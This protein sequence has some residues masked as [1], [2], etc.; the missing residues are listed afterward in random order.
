MQGSQEL[1]HYKIMTARF[2]QLGPEWDTERFHPED[3]LIP[4]CRLYFPIAGEGRVTYLGKTY[5]L[6]RGTMLL[7]PPL[8]ITRIK[9]DDFLNKYWVHFNV[10]NNQSER[11]LFMFAGR[12]LE[13]RVPEEKFSFITELFQIMLPFYRKTPPIEKLTAL[14]EELANNALSLLLAPFLEMILAE[15][16]T[17]SMDR[18]MKLLDYMNSHIE[19]APSLQSLSKV[20]GIGPNYLSSLF[21][22]HLGASP[23]A[24][25]NTLRMSRIRLDLINESMSFASIAEKWGFPSSQ[26]FSKWLKRQKGLS[27]RSYRKRGEF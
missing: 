23:V 7:V 19:E 16:S 3:C 2:E 21:R 6:K 4:F 10:W 27:P 12:C 17:P 13:W 8:A 22:K 26:A 11:D 25:R 5:T 9:C 20:A 14:D 24:F 18:F 15:E 1:F